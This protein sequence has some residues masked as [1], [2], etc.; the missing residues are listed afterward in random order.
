MTIAQ[1]IDSRRSGPPEPRLSR[2]LSDSRFLMFV[3]DEMAADFEQHHDDV[4]RLTLGKSELPPDPVVVSAMTEA[5]ADHRRASLVYPAGLPQ[6][7][8]RL[9]V[10]Y[11]RT[12]GVD[13]P[14]ERFIVSTGTSTAFRNLFQLLAAP[15]DEIVVPLP[16]YPLYVFSARLA[17]A[18]V[19]YYRIDPHTMTVDFDSLAEAVGERT[20]AVVVN[21]PGNPYGNLVGPD[22]FRRI[23]AVVAGRA[24]LVSDEIYNNVQFDAASYS[25]VQFAEELRCPLVVTNAFSKAHRMYARRVGYAIVPP[26]MVEPLTVIQHHTLLTTD[27]VP[28]FGAIAALDNQ[29]GVAELRH[30]YGERRDHTMARFATVPDVRALPSSGGFYHTLDCHEYLRRHGIDTSLELAEQ[31]MRAVRVATVPGSDFGVPDTLRLSY[32]ATRYREAVDRLA[33]FF[34]RERAS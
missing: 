24:V 1:E 4:V 26:R 21:S 18:T 11:Q 16:Y 7:R 34:T 14:A 9:A 2:S 29:H 6:L 23:D 33:D 13:V 10:E 8:E 3:L 30:L 22:D 17:D 28:Q 27:P 31:I 15:G 32:S 20:R 19:R 5:L 12:Y 25:A